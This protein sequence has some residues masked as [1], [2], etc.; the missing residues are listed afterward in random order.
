MSNVIGRR[1]FA[2][3]A[4]E[5]EKKAIL[6]RMDEHSERLA[7]TTMRTKCCEL[8]EYDNPYDGCH[9]CFLMKGHTGQHHDLDTGH[10]WGETSAEEPDH[11]AGA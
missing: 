1:E 6:Q 10:R 3:R 2:K 7:E 5:V 11:E 9:V 8:L 4:Y